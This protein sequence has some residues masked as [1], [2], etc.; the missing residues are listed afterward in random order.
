MTV[1]RALIPTNGIHITETSYPN[2]FQVASYDAQGFCSGPRWFP[3]FVAAQ[4]YART[5]TGK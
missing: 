3:T 4:G 2:G 1:T 5:L